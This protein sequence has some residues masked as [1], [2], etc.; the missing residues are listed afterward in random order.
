[1]I[2]PTSACIFFCSIEFYVLTVLDIHVFLLEINKFF[3][4]LA[5]YFIG[6]HYTTTTHQI[7][8]PAAVRE[9]FEIDVGNQLHYGG[10]ANVRPFWRCADDQFGR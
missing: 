8:W 1:M 10:K 6:N 3:P 2:P 9:Q 5:I 4:A 7:S